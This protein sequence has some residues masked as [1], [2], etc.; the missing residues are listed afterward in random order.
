MGGSGVA[1]RCLVGHRSGPGR[2]VKMDRMRE[3]R[4]HANGYT[5]RSGGDGL[6]HRRRPLNQVYL[7]AVTA[8][9]SCT[10][11]LSGDITKYEL[12]DAPP[13]RMPTSVTLSPLVIRKTGE[14]LSPP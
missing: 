6:R 12:S 11:C 8:P 4:Q 9:S 2:S 13:Q 10:I 3:S 14:P 1:S 7:V 5:Q